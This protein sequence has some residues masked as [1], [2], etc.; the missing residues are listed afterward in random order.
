LTHFWDNPDFGWHQFFLIR[1]FVDT[2][3]TNPKFSWQRKPKN[4]SSVILLFLCFAPDKK[5]GQAPKK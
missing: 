3:I 2:K 4:L 1:G 5:S